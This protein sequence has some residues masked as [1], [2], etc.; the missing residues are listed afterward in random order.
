MTKEESVY[1]STLNAF[2]SDLDPNPVQP[3]INRM[4]RRASL[5]HH[6]R[7]LWAIVRPFGRLR[8]LRAHH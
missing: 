5:S 8:G 7:V 6:H 2:G 4:R 1:A 3:R